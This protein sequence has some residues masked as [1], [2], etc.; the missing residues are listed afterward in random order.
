MDSVRTRHGFSSDAAEKI[1][2][3]HLGN[4]AFVTHRDQCATCSAARPIFGMDGCSEGMKILETVLDE[5]FAKIDEVNANK[6]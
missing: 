6:N 1:W 5:V 3:D 2:T 4:N